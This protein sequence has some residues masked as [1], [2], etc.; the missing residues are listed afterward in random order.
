MGG[1]KG[2]HG[3]WSC[4]TSHDWRNVPMCQTRAQNITKEMWQRMVIKSETWS[5]RPVHSRQTR[6]FEDAQRSEVA[7]LSN[8]TCRRWKLSVLET[9]WSLIFS[10][11]H[12]DTKSKS[13]RRPETNTERDKKNA[14]RV[15]LVTLP[16]ILPS[17]LLAGP[18][19]IACDLHSFLAARN[20][21]RSCFQ[22]LSATSL[23]TSAHSK[24]SRCNDDQAG[25]EQR[26]VQNGQVGSMTK[27]RREQSEKLK[28]QNWMELKKEKTECRMK[29]D[30]VLGTSDWRARAS[31]RSNTTQQEKKEHQSTHV[32]FTDSHALND[33]WRAHH[34]HV[35]KHQSRRPTIAIHENKVCCE[36][37]NNVIKTGNLHHIER[38]QTSE[39][40][41]QCCVE[42][43]KNRRQLRE[44]RNSWTCLV[45]ER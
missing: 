14:T 26:S 42:K 36:Y 10:F 30:V 31:S 27:Q 13:K 17:C 18:H 33:G 2:R 19:A 11:S 32:P 41:D 21:V 16:M 1:S 40:H 45:I 29:K 7:V 37:S 43:L 20:R 24:H 39:H 15:H 6:E 23:S 12:Y 22:K 38:R 28:D 35:T 25:R 44:W 34:H 9:S 8:W 5:K 3:L 4:K